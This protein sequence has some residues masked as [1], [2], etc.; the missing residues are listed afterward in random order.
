MNH[1]F[2]EL[3]KD[4]AQ[5]VTRRAVLKQFSIGLAGLALAIVVALPAPALATSRGPLIELSRP[6]A[7]GGCN[8]G[9]ALD[10]PATS[11][12]L[13]DAFDTFI[14]VNPV[15][16]KNIVATWTQG[17]VQNIVAAV[18]FDGG[19]TWQRVP[20]PFT[21][22]SGGPFLGAGDERLCFAPNGDVH[23]IAVVGNDLAATGIAVCKSTDGGLHWSAPVVLEG[24]VGLGP[25]HQALII[26]D[27]ADARYLYGIW[28]G[29][30]GARGPAVFSRTIDGGLTW[31]PVRPIVQTRPQDYVQFSQ[32]LVL[33]DGTLLDAYALINIRNSGHGLRQDL[34]LEII[35]STD[36]GQTWS[37]QTQAAIMLPLYG[38]PEG[39]SLV[40]N[41]E[42][43]QFVSDPLN[44]SVAV[45][46]RNG[47]L[48]AVWGDG[49][50][51]NFQYNDIAFSMSTNSGFTWS[52]PIRVNQ[53]PLNIPAVNRQ[54]FMPTL[55]VAGDGTI[56]VAYYD[57]RFNDPNS[58]LP[59]DYWLARCKP[60][61]TTPATNPASWGGEVRLTDS[62]FN[63]AACFTLLGDFYIGESFGLATVGKDFVSTF[64]QVDQDN[65]AAIFF[66]RVQQ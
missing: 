52:A 19:G 36:R 62:S 59:T 41:P 37:S 4:L 44:P 12:T 9:F 57:F 27:P 45:D 54:C 39:N 7:V 30:D 48:Y 58:G 34:S 50:F 2:D 35:R 43:G 14:A 11:W 66:R 15:N 46:K 51:S 42:T 38:G 20:I 10:L 8:D 21:V 32:L 25:V 40:A 60:S 47:N 49:R 3:I 6:N 1:P 64:T 22:C 53:T 16:P 18:S 5:S 28:D 65:V 26:A 23:V 55:A 63:I 61:S 33:P 24:S 56:G 29:A 17:P 31:E 13:D